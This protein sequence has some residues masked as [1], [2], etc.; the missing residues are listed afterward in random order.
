MEFRRVLFRSRRVGAV[1]R[2]VPHLDA[3]PFAAAEVDALLDR[4]RPERRTAGQVDT[5]AIDLA[6]VAA[7]DFGEGGREGPFDLRAH[8]AIASER[9]FVAALGAA[10]REFGN[11]HFAGGGEELAAAP[12]V[13]HALPR[14]DERRVGKECVRTCSSQWSQYHK[15]KKK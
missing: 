13:E 5:L 4:A 10:D 8:H 14:S 7:D 3:R 12:R 1:R 6:A 9:G 2:D 15:K 11:Q